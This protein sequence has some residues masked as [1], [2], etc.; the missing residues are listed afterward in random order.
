MF[1]RWFFVLLM[2][3]SIQNSRWAFADEFLAALEMTVKE[4]RVQKVYYSDLLEY[5]DQDHQ[6]LW[7]GGYQGTYPGLPSAP[8]SNPA[9]AFLMA[10]QSVIFWDH[11]EFQLEQLKRFYASL[12]EGAFKTSP[13]QRLLVEI[14]YEFNQSAVIAFYDLHS[15]LNLLRKDYRAYRSRNGYPRDHRVTQRLLDSVTTSLDQIFAVIKQR[16]G[17]HPHWRISSVDGLKEALTQLPT[18]LLADQYYSDFKQSI[19]ITQF[20]AQFYQGNLADIKE[21]EDQVQ[22]RQRWVRVI[23]AYFN[24]SP[25]TIQVASFCDH[26]FVEQRRILLTPAELSE[27]DQLL[28]GS[29]LRR[30]F[31]FAFSKRDQILGELEV[32][33]SDY[34]RLKYAHRSQVEGGT[35]EGSLELSQSSSVLHRGEDL[36]REVRV[37]R[38]FDF[39]RGDSQDDQEAVS[40][41]LGPQ[42]GGEIKVSLA[43]DSRT[44]SPLV[45]EQK[46]L[47][48]QGEDP[49]SQSLR[50]YGGEECRASAETQISALHL[51]AVELRSEDQADE[52]PDPK[53]YDYLQALREEH[54]YYQKLKKGRMSPAGLMSQ[55]EGKAPETGAAVLHSGGQSSSPLSV[56]ELS[57]EIKLSGNALDTYLTVMGKKASRQIRN[58]EVHE[59]VRVLGGRL[60][61]TLGD[62][63]IVLPHRTSDAK[64]PE[65]IFKMHFRHSGRETFPLGTLRAFFGKAIERAG[66]VPW[67]KFD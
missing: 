16:R 30:S 27:L 66:L 39:N 60:D 12:P 47:A 49:V 23:S 17:V 54:E 53:E 8:F 67:I 38:E 31:H 50:T 56:E 26:E 33:N 5:L 59:L 28:K 41:D 19:Y 20:L 10:Q 46:E 45:T 14:L 34:A 40:E 11:A 32:M 21:I 29:I 62:V 58:R 35:S 57:R 63:R 7:A 1:S 22:E 61:F 43:T 9:M 2:M 13:I 48:T 15:C 36:T 24:A 4:A 18:S 6:S 51:S 65:I 3:G 25:K 37:E 42:A 55:A 64:E 44:L 52:F